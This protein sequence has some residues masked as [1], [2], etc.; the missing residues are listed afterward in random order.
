MAEKRDWELVLGVFSL[1][2]RRMLDGAYDYGE[3]NPATDKRDLLR[4]AQE[5][6]LDAMNYLGMQYLKLEELKKVDFREKTRKN[7]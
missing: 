6:L 4:E 5:E 2:A 7:P 1:A 3:F